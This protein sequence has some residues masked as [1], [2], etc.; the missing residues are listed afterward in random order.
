MTLEQFNQLDDSEKAAQL[1]LCCG[2]QA[3]KESI[4]KKFPFETERELLLAADE[5]WQDGAESDWKEA[6]LHHPKIGD[7]ESL[8]QKFASTASLAL[9]EQSSV[10]SA[11]DEILQKLK[12]GNEDY[13][14]K[15]GY[16]FIVCAT[17]KSA[18][19]M[20][21]ILELRLKNDPAT[22]IMIAMQ[23]QSKITGL[24]L[25]KLLS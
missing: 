6:F 21:E 14:A 7:L 15:F 23:E 1:E 22:E 25:K 10:N 13:E 20:L 3:W 4:L 12:R 9:G 18:A 2:S 19:E 17:G 24:R 11:S 16:I 5:C 8:R